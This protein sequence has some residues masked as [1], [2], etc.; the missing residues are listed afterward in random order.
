MTRWQPLCWLR[1]GLWILAGWALPTL[2]VVQA[3]TEMEPPPT[4]DKPVLDTTLHPVL[5]NRVDWPVIQGLSLGM[6]MKEVADITKHKLELDLKLEEEDHYYFL[7]KGSKGLQA[8][9][10]LRTK[11]LPSDLIIQTD[12]HKKVIAITLSGTLMKRLFH[13]P[14]ET[15]LEMFVQQFATDHH[16]K[17]LTAHDPGRGYGWYELDS[18]ER[19]NLKVD[20]S[21]RLRLVGV[22]ADP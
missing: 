4:I 21:W 8:G 5:T 17:A 6:S 10:D 19:F 3:A 22:A 12:T 16:L 11:S 20:N 7:P 18:P 13:V 2:P 14:E 1:I 15:P 9:S